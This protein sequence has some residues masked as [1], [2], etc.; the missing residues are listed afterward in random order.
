[1]SKRRVIRPKILD[2]KGISQKVPCS[3]KHVYD[4]F[5]GACPGPELAKRL[6]EVTGIDRR[7]FIW[8]E[9]FPHPAIRR[10]TE[11]RKSFRSLNRRKNKFLSEE[12]S[13]K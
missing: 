9:E 12:K 13:E 4:V 7:C 5:T 3:L 10:A 2:F 11:A 8:P 6:E 1:M